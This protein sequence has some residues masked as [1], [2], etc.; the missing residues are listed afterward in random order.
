[1]GIAGVA[2]F[3]G[4]SDVHL[5]DT[6]KLL[7]GDSSD[8]QIHH[9]GTDSNILGSYG[10]LYIQN[11]GSDAD[12]INIRAQDDINLQVQNGEAGINIIGDGAVELYHD[13]AR[14]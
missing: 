7:I 10:D 3:S 5:H 8:L 2:T 6:V 13:N 9:N 1:M 14:Y 12:D 11:T 4:T